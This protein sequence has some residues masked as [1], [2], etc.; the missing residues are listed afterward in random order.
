MVHAAAWLVWKGRG[1][2]DEENELSEWRIGRPTSVALVMSLIAVSLLL[3]YWRTL[4]SGEYWW[5]LPLMGRHSKYLFLPLIGA[6]AAL[7]IDHRRLCKY[8]GAALLTLGLA[9]AIL[10]SSFFLAHVAH[11]PSF[12]PVP[13]FVTEEAP[14]API[15]EVRIEGNH[16]GLELSPGGKRFFTWTVVEHGN[17]DGIGSVAFRV[18]DFDGAATTIAAIAAGFIDDDRILALVATE[19]AHELR[20]LDAESPDVVDWR[21]AF[22]ETVPEDIELTVDGENWRLMS[23]LRHETT[24]RYAGVVGVDNIERTDWSGSEHPN[25]QRFAAAGDHLLQLEWTRPE[26]RETGICPPPRLGHSSRRQRLQPK[27][28]RPRREPFAGEHELGRAMRWPWPSLQRD[29]LSLRWAGR[30]S[31]LVGRPR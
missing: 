19:A 29:P 5:R 24:V 12:A 1:L 27:V 21:L 30:R 7:A 15:K 2:D 16:W 28:A 3:L 4:P 17:D 20:S 8:A 11:D 26:D 13:E 6:G 14:Y 10:G 23:G 9:P 22:P 31:R 25:H 18:A